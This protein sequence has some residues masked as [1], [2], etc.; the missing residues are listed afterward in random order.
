[1]FRTNSS[2]GRFWEGRN[3]FGALIQTIQD[4]TR[5]VCF[6]LRNDR[7][8]KLRIAYYLICYPYAVKRQVR[9]VEETD[10]LEMLWDDKQYRALLDSKNLPNVIMAAVTHELRLATLD[11]TIDQFKITSIERNLTDALAQ[12]ASAEKIS[13]TPVPYVFAIEGSRFLLLYLLTFPA[14]IVV[15]CRRPPF[16][17]LAVLTLTTRPSRSRPCPA[18]Y[19]RLGHHP[20]RLSPL[21]PA[22]RH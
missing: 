2:Y 8:R 7:E 20:G 12:R 17:A 4:T 9:S 10:E 5:Q 3:T 19:A 1:M 16:A 6:A 11:K 18:A 21:L 22:H 14:I 13:S 15:R